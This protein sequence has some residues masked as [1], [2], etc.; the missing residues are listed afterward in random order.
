MISNV[1][2]REWRSH[3]HYSPHKGEGL[4]TLY[5]EASPAERPHFDVSN[6]ICQIC[7]RKCSPGR[8]DT[9]VSAQNSTGT[10]QC[11]HISHKC[12]VELEINL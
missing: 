9:Q 7:S 8:D 10:G 2:F 1:Q 12:L 4:Y 3:V 11:Y 5:R 6:I